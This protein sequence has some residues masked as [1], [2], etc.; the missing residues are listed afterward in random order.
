MPNFNSSLKK[1]CSAYLLDFTTYQRISIFLIGVLTYY[2]IY[3]MYP[4]SYY[5][6]FVFVVLLKENFIND[7]R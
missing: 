4:W 2:Q 7:G 6:Y 3:T 1:M 5:K